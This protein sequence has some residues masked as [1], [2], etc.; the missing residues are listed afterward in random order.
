M[1]RGGWR[2]WRRRVGRSE[3]GSHWKKDEERRMAKLE[4]EGGEK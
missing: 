2:S 4:K 1:R 3:E